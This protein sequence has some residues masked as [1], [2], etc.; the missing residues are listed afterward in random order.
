MQRFEEADTLCEERIGMCSI[1]PYI[2]QC[3]GRERP[4][5]TFSVANL[6]PQRQAGRK[7]RDGLHRVGALKGK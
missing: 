4:G 7:E 1:L 6:L 5:D 3:Q 2:H